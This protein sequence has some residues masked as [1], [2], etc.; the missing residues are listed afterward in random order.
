MYWWSTTT[1]TWRY[2]ERPLYVLIIWRRIWR[3][4]GYSYCSRSLYIFICN[5]RIGSTCG[6]WCVRAPVGGGGRWYEK[7]QLIIYVTSIERKEGAHLSS[8]DSFGCFWQK[9]CMIEVSPNRVCWH[10]TP[11]PFCIQ[12]VSIDSQRTGWGGG[13]VDKCKE[14]DV[15]TPTW[16][17]WSYA[18][19][20]GCAV[21]ENYFFTHTL[22]ENYPT[23][24]QGDKELNY[25]SHS[26]SMLVRELYDKS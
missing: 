11:P 22:S 13:G 16:S 25:S 14:R 20:G 9:I 2:W 24:R 7:A 1:R 8:G 19:G 17:D 12:R 18:G 5:L 6:V 10:Q 26:R 15:I 23:I 3:R 21:C 4:Q